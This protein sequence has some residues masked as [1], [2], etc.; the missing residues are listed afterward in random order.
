MHRSGRKLKSRSLILYQRGCACDEHHRNNIIN[1]DETIVSIC[2]I[3]RIRGFEQCK[4]IQVFL[5]SSK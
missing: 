1:V 3:T 2:F 4:D 5:S